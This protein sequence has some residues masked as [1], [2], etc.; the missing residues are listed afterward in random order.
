MGLFSQFISHGSI[1][2]TYVEFIRR[3]LR[4]R[5]DPGRCAMSPDD[6]GNA[7]APIASCNSI[8]QS[9][10]NA[11]GTVADFENAAPSNCATPN[12]KDVVNPFRHRNTSNGTWKSSTASVPTPFV[13]VDYV[14]NHGYDEL[15]LNP[16][17]NAWGV[18]GLPSAAPDTRVRTL[19]S[20]PTRASRTP[21]GV[22]LSL[23]QRFWHGLQGAL[24]LIP[25]VIRSMTYLTAISASTA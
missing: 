4:L 7:A 23:R 25:T 18:G 3:S 9:N 5:I 16:Y 11:G 12:L 8:F 13:S 21:N 10:Y 22:T 19:S 24:R 20:S 15:L 1:L 6:V 14:G 17:L 2:I